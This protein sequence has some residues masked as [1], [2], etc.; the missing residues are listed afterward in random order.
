MRFDLKLS[1]GEGARMRKLADYLKDI[2]KALDKATHSYNQA[3]GSMESRALPSARKFKDLGVGSGEEIPAL[4][5]TEK[6]VR[7]LQP[8]ELL[9]GDFTE[10]KH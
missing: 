1:S 4:E 3:V 6:Q 9:E 10:D 2:G 8:P 5:P 7:D